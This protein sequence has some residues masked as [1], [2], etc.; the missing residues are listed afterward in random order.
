MTTER[1]RKKKKIYE[2]D[3]KR[4]EQRVRDAGRA[5]KEIPQHLQ[6]DKSMYLYMH[7]HFK[8]GISVCELGTSFFY[9]C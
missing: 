3:G 6:L 7:L 1:I 2:T 5:Q 8:P 4:A 9:R